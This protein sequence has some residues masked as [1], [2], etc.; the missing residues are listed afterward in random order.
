MVS[1]F[2]NM[3]NLHYFFSFLS[4][5]SYA[6]SLSFQIS[7]FD[8][9]M[10]SI[11]YQGDA[12]PSA[13]TIEFNIVS[14]NYRVGWATYADNVLLWDTKTGKL[15]DFNTTFSFEINTLDASRYG[16]GLCFFLAPVGFQIPKNSAGG[17]LGLFNTTTSYSSSNQMVS[18]EFDSFEDPE[19]DP[20]G[21]GGHVGININTITS[22]VY[23][24]WNA[25]FHSKDTA[26]V[27]V[28]YDAVAKNLSVFWSYST[29]HNPLE[30]SSIS[31]QL[32]QVDLMNVLPERV[33][34]GF[35]AA[36]GQYVERHILKSWEF[37]SILK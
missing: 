34:I 15:A 23:A 2:R 25:S 30:K 37:H 18:I 9:T 6:N 12:K 14:F 36:T 5:L 11:V 7:R 4:V 33:M 3:V 26:N 16:D 21:I 20:H 10:K 31:F 19:W 35:S 22:A 29:T 28:T 8:P 13:G 32:D 27:S 1:R 24:Q 17:F